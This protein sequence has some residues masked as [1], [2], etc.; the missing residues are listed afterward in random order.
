[1]DRASGHNSSGLVVLGSG[2]EA[3]RTLPL[4]EGRHLIGRDPQSGLRLVDPTV[5]RTHAAITL[6][7]QGVWIEDLGST[8]GT[9]VNHDL[10]TG[11]R[12]LYPGDQIQLGALS[13]RLDA[14]A[15]A[16]ATAFLPPAVDRSS[17]NQNIGSQHD[18][19]FYNA[20]RD[21]HISYVQQIQRQREPFLREIA[22][23]RTK[24][25]WLVWLGVLVSV[26]SIGWALVILGGSFSI[27]IDA[28]TSGGS[29][30]ESRLRDWF[31]PPILG[32]P[33]FIWAAGLSTAGMVLLIVGIVLHVTATAR[34][35][36]VDREL[37]LI[38]RGP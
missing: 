33:S 4:T 29:F 12:P 8:G 32:V 11:A 36:R 21:Q 13:L 7:D 10:L 24:A 28:M 20:G 18:G 27:L 16:A 2:P 34:R 3:G 9:R 37:P 1:M 35:R 14:G 30:D 5:S 17:S 23:T 31:G 15:A 6:T 38:R 22:A 19:H 25:R 26:V